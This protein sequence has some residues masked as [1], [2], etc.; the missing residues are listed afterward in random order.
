VQSNYGSQRP[1]SAGYNANFQYSDPMAGHNSHFSGEKASR[2]A[3]VPASR[4]FSGEVVESRRRSSEQYHYHQ[5][6]QPRHGAAAPLPR[7]EEPT[8]PVLL[9]HTCS[10][11][12]QMRSA[13]Y[14]R[15]NPVVPGKPL[16]LTPCRRCKKKTKSQQRS[17]SSYTRIRSCTAEKPCDWPGESVYI[18]LERNERRGRRRS[19]EGVH[20]YTRSPTRPRIVRRRSS[21][22]RLGLRALQQEQA[23]PPV[24]RNDTNI[25][26]S[27]L[28]PRRASR[29]DG[30]W[31]P[32]DVV[33]MQPAQCEVQHAPPSDPNMTSRDE[34][35]PPP[36]V[37]PTHTFR[38]VPTTLLR[39]QSSRI[40]EL[41]PSPPPAQRRSTRVVYQS[42]SFERRPRSVSPVRISFRDERRSEGV[43]A[44]LM[45]HPRPYRP[46]MPDH[47]HSARVSEETASMS[48]YMPRSR[49]DSPSHS[50]LKAPAGERETLRRRMSM[51]ESQQSTRVEVDDHRVHFGSERREEPPMP[52][53]RGSIRYTDEASRSG[54]DYTLHQDYA[55]QR[56]VDD[57]LSPPPIEQMDRLRVRRVSLSPRRNYEEDIR[58]DRARRLS[59]SPAPAP[60]RYEETRVRY[61]SPLPPRD[62]ERP[63]QPRPSPLPERRP[64]SGYRHVSRT[65][66]LA[67]PRSLT[68]PSSRRPASDDMT[69][70]GSAHSGEVTEVRSWRGIDENGKPA[71]FVE[72]RKTERGEFRPLTEKSAS[73][74]LRDV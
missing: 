61:V 73:R 31:P 8:V 66:A 16:V 41:S 19:R 68:P 34:V 71:T 30:V 11:C 1:L 23:V 60:R 28:S 58:I 25:R 13:G 59:P 6:G 5:Y 35:W 52:A 2:G 37:V 4:N 40:I 48:D 10:V 70:S 21:Q 36:D 24:L 46:V 67:R 20:V 65:E 22:I 63:P 12:S 56:V 51:R 26:I 39:R 3:M 42:K 14:H 47:R 54:G 32:P 7:V 64:Y 55:R 43:E 49:R 69:D 50:I 62:R 44:R 74:S 27:S 9:C 53:S 45:S 17:R 18:D 72:E 15:N 29:Y 33:R 38:K 57:P